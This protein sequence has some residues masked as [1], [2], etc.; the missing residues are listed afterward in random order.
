MGGV[1]RTSGGSERSKRGGV[2]TSAAQYGPGVVLGRGNR[3]VHWGCSPAVSWRRR[4]GAAFGGVRDDPP[5]AT[6]SGA[7]LGGVA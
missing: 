2:A 6:K 7:E 4:S 3:R 5:N 1:P